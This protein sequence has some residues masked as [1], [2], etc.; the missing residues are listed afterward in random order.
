MDS[1]ASTNV[2]KANNA[3]TAAGVNA[4][5]LN[6]GVG[7]V[8]VGISA[9]ASNVASSGST[10][11]GYQAGTLCTGVQNTCVGYQS[12]VAAS[13]G[14]ENTCIGYQAGADITTGSHN[15]ALGALT[16]SGDVLNNIITIGYAAEAGKSNTCV[17]G[18][19]TGVAVL[20]TEDS[21][22]YYKTSGSPRAG[23]ITAGH[24]L[25][26]LV[27]STSHPTTLTLDT[28][29]NLVAAW[30][31]TTGL[32]GCKAGNA[33]EF[34]MQNN[35]AAPITLLAGVGCTLDLASVIHPAQTTKP[36]IAVLTNVALGTEAYKLYG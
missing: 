10:H 35:Y 23:P 6:T 7:T 16:D 3:T 11:V 24:M 36:Y 8:A 25:S 15:I 19:D 27:K 34:I 21:H 28:A 32:P 2:L 20:E 5:A 17:I 29:V 26:G 14:T 30:P 33:I 31:T 4:G 22:V 1:I 13:T 12:G 9:G 18:G